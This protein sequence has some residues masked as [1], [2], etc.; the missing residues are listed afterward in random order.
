M[1]E[2]YIANLNHADPAVRYEAAQ[3]LGA[4]ND[5]RAIR[6]LIDVLPDANAKVQYAAF[7]GLIKLNAGEAAEPI[8]DL[9]L[10]NLDSKIWD[11]LKLNIGLRLRAGLLEMMP[12]GD[13]RMTEQ[14]VAALDNDTLDDHQRAL[15]LRLLG[16]TATNDRVD[17]LIDILLH[18]SPVI[19]GAAAEALGYLGDADGVNPL[20]IF[21]HDSSDEL[22]EI[23]AEALGRI[24]DVRAF[25]AILPLLKDENEWVRRA[26]A[27]ALGDL[28]DRRA[29]EPLS[30]MLQDENTVVVDAAFDALKKLS[31]GRYDVDVTL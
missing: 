26:A 11:L 20:L 18:G 10:T 3:K 6:P 28:G 29:I 24:G 16:R 12:H 7:S 31:Y 4:S 14:L 2:Q 8:L 1:F 21:L 9:L 22:R 5:S 17:M 25:D 13:A 19:Q 30:D 27:A 23:A 15:F